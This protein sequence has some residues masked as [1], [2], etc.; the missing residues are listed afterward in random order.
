MDDFQEEEKFDKMR[1]THFT[2]LKPD[3]LNGIAIAKNND[4]DDD[5][6]DDDEDDSSTGI[7]LKRDTYGVS[8]S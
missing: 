8:L 5:E 1:K 3:D 2:D 4:P 6:D 7:F